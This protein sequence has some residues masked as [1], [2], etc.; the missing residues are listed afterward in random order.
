MM[1]RNVLARER[2][3]GLCVCVWGGATTNAVLAT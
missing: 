1:A 2:S 3:R